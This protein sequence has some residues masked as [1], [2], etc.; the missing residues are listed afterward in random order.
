MAD[1]TTTYTGPL[2]ST[3]HVLRADEYTVAARQ[4]EAAASLD[5]LSRVDLYN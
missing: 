1:R 3:V 5:V 2:G 4:S